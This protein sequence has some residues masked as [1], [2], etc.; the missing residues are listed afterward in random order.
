MIYTADYLIER[1][2]AR[3]EE[4]HDVEYDRELRTAIVD[5]LANNKTLLE[6]VK[7]KPEKL[8]E[9]V[10]IV[11][12]K[13]Q[14]TLPFFLN[15]VQL[16]F[17]DVLNKAIYDY[18]KGLIPEISILI[19][20]GRQ[21]GFTTLVT[22]YQL[23]SSILNKNFQGFTLADTSKNATDIFQQKAKFP[24]NQLPERL[25]PTEKF[26]NQRQLLFE[27]LNSSWVVDAAT[28]DVGRSKTINFF[29]GS[30]CAFW[31]NGIAPIQ[32][33][34]GN[35]FTRNC[36]K[37][38][39]STANGYNDY[40]EMWA[41][42]V[43]INCFF[44][45]WKT[46]EYRLNF[47]SDKV[48][49]E[50]ISFIRAG[51]E[52]INERLAWLLDDKKLDI[53]QVYWYFKKWESYIE[54]DLMRQEYP[55]TP[56]EAFLLSGKTVFDTEKLIARL[57]TVP[58]PIKTGYFEYDYDGLKITRIRWVNDKNGYIRLYKLPS[59]LTFTKCC[60]GGDTAGE[61]SDNFTA[62]VLDAKTGE[63]VAVMEHK[64]NEDQYAKQIYCLGKYYRNY[65]LK[66]A[67]IAVEVNFSTF[68]TMELQR[69]GYR[70]MYI[71]EKLDEYTGKPEK[72][73]GFKTTA[74]T[75]P[76]IV[77]ALV[78]IVRDHTE[79]INDE[80]T[81]RELLKIVKNEKGKI[82]APQGAH[83]DH[84]MGLA[85]AYHARTQVRFEVEERQMP[86]QSHFNAEKKQQITSDYGEQITVV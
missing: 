19:L 60:I 81:L 29:H 55:C 75:R 42:G 80:V 54:K 7:R 68:V 50:F 40:Q 79:L 67:L 39:E 71:R 85:I 73:F 33:G 64:F 82:E 30:E 86:S 76:T 47:P 4:K 28:D 78:E 31:R 16:E 25:K 52:W 58:K 77:S 65:K 5:E 49:E 69:L 32:A 43:H 13:E 51:K 9:L 35:A 1:R 23:A 66:E 84:M 27:K 8:I 36:I 41:S 45:W 15:A 48:K 44:E 3:W 46:E 34:L 2:K 38:Y 20:K 56:D 6:E 37:I 74:L 83:D 53:E 26:N 21:Q 22:A 61:G 17:M 24:Y 63:Q 18:D 57:A 11:V 72:R 59:Q 62:H 14:H 12:D 10:F 70:N